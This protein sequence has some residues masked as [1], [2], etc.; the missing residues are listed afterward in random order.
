LGAPPSLAVFALPLEVDDAE[1]IIELNAGLDTVA[2]AVDVEI[3]RG[4][5]RLVGLA[6]L[7]EAHPAVEIERSGR[8]QPDERVPHALRSGAEQVAG[9]VQAIDVEITQPQPPA[10]ISRDPGLPPRLPGCIAMRGL[11]VLEIDEAIAIGDLSAEF[12]PAIGKR[13]RL[14]RHG[15]VPRRH[16]DREAHTILRREEL[17]RH[18]EI[19][20][21][22]WLED[23][24]QAP[25]GG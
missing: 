15:I 1:D 16:S 25:R 23:R 10:T 9:H 6:A 19:D 18:V 12:L 21:T 17:E 13:G 20:Q 2:V 24:P 14:E 7:G 3:P 5:E 4:A 22:L 11:E 8:I